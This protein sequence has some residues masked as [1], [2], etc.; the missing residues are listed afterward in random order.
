[1]NRYECQLG[2]KCIRPRAHPNACLE[3]SHHCKAQASSSPTTTQ[4]TAIQDATAFV[5]KLPPDPSSTKVSIRQAAAKH[6]KIPHIPS[7][8]GA[9]D[10]LLPITPGGA[11]TSDDDTELDDCLSLSTLHTLHRPPSFK[12]QRRTASGQPAAHSGRALS[13]LQHWLKARH[14]T[15]HASHIHALLT[16]HT[17]H[18]PYHRWKTPRWVRPC[19]TA[20]PM[21][22]SRISSP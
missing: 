17:M 20:A 10:A 5:Y 4:P 9:P 3:T 6:R 13:T 12:S 1:M 22:L 2:T 14:I 11:T 8:E 21:A 18:V 7:F 19:D 15:V 16:L